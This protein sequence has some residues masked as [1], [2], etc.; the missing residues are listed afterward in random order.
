MNLQRKNNK[1]FKISVLE[2][3]YRKKF[4]KQEFFENELYQSHFIN[5]LN[6]RTGEELIK[7]I[8]TNSP[9]SLNKKEF[10]RFLLKQMILNL[11]PL[12]YLLLGGFNKFKERI[13]VDEKQILKDSGLLEFQNKE[14]SKWWLDLKKLLRSKE[15]KKK[16]DLGDEGEQASKDF[17]EKRIKNLGINNLVKR[18]SFYDES[19]GYDIESWNI[20]NNKIFN[21]YI[22]VKNNS[23]I[24]KSGQWREACSKKDLYYAHYWTRNCKYLKI[25]EFPELHKAVTQQINKEHPPGYEWTLKIPFSEGKPVEEYFNNF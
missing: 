10:L 23:F 21:I 13:D 19:L 24:F 4:N 7:K 8:D 11:H 18:S 1:F 5:N 3:V 25:I 2:Y 9:N 6:N 20:K 22:E 16:Q 17:E 15:N 14:I 12:S